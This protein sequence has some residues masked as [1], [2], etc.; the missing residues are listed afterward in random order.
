[1]EMDEHVRKLPFNLV[2]ETL[3]AKD[4]KDV[5]DTNDIKDKGDGKGAALTVG[6]KMILYCRR[7]RPYVPSPSGRG[8]G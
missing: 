2:Q 3:K 6:A 7:K 4:T 1:M 5:K 8:P